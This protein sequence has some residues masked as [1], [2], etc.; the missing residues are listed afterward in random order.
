MNFNIDDLSLSFSF[1][2]GYDQ[3]TQ[4]NIVRMD[5]NQL[6][7]YGFVAICLFEIK[8]IIDTDEKELSCSEKIN[9]INNLILSY[10]NSKNYLKSTNLE[11]DINKID[12]ILKE[13]QEEKNINKDKEKE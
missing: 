4:K 13:I 6:K 8:R 5:K 2:I 10:K 1:D 11:E 12:L 9:K 7:S 3:N